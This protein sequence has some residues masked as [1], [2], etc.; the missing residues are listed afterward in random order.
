MSERSGKPKLAM[1][2]ASSCGGCEVSLL[3]ICEKLLDVDRNYEIVFLPCLTDFKH[4]DVRGY[5]E[6]YIDLC[7]FN[8][9]IRSSENEEMARLLRRKSRVLVA[10]GSCAHEGCV[11]ALANLTSGDKILDAVYRRS[12][13]TVNRQGLLPGRHTH[14]PTGEIRLP[15]FY[16]TVRTLDQVEKVDF[17]VPGCPP[18]SPRVWEVLELLTAVFLEGAALPEPGSVIGAN[19][20]ALCEE[21]PLERR[22]RPVPRFHRPYEIVPDRSTCLLEQGLVCLG[23]A[24][25]GGCGALCPRTA[26]GC[27]GCYGPPDGVEDQGA[28]MT[29]ALAA[30]TDAGLSQTGERAL[31]EKVMETMGTVVDPAGTFYRFSMGHSLLRRARLRRDHEESEQKE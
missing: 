2:W 18:E 14:S 1:Y 10:F 9:A 7:L 27:R 31:R 11:P 12:P 17:Y 20:V 24:T 19:P 26:M 16:D 23:P 30:A 28:R 8:G 13:S 4:D 29:A 21:C 15:A 6:G 5:P 3:N 22:S 25:R